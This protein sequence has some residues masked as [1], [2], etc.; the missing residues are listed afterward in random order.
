MSLTKEL[1]DFLIDRSAMKVGFVTK[2][3]LEGGPPSTD[4]TYVLPEAESAVAFA[5][6]LDKEK[7]RAFLGK[8]LPDGR[9][10]HEK[11]N[12]DMRTKAFRLAKEAGTI[13]EDKL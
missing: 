7:I 4:L 6:P 13:L 12:W 10:D 5:V 11:D 2:K 8:D 1:E 3:S 9:I